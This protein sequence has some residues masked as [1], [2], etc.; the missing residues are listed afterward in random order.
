[1][2]NNMIRGTG[3]RYLILLPLIVAGILSILASGSSSDGAGGGS[4]T[5]P[6]T[7]TLSL[8]PFASGLTRP[9]GVYNAGPGDDRLF[10]IEL[11]GTIRIV[12]SNGA[13]VTT[14]FLDISSRVDSD[15]GEEGLLGLAF[16]PN[17]ATNGFF[18]VNYTS[19]TD[20]RRTRISRFTVTGNRNVADPNSEVILLTV[21][22]P[23]ANHNAGDIHFGP[24]GF[25]YIPLGDGG[26]GGD[27]DDN[28]QNKGLLLGKV[29]RI[30][31]DSGAGSAPDC[32][33]LG[34]G[35]YRIPASNPFIGVPAV[36]DEIWAVGLR[37]PWRSSFDRLTG[38]F[39]I[40]DV[41]QGA[42]EEIDF[43][44]AGTAGG[45]NY[46]WRCFEGNHS[47]NASGCG[48][49]TTYTFPVFEYSHDG[50][51]C[52]VIVGYVYRGTLFPA[53]AGRYVF[54]DLCSGNFWD[55][56]RDGTGAWRVA[57]HTNL[58]L[59]GYVSFGEDTNGEV[60]LVHQENGTLSR[61]QGM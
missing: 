3:W 2:L 19:T 40:A 41:G 24:D 36:C 50:G 32:V 14:P 7:V 1:M 52:S 53:L 5:V 31:V 10:V 55:M 46:G 38:D 44:P 12:Q 16:H 23:F 18:Y 59:S 35:E 30:D 42:W 6:P 20:R 25:L 9:V 15:E 37:N 49:N 34:T 60:Y 51:N 13:R 56:I 28:A 58:A 29:V 43:R 47:F 26:G 61:L 11:A 45:Q 8:T 39:F 54:T 33:G 27:Q 21:D 57:L 4:P 48:A 17:Y 22:Q